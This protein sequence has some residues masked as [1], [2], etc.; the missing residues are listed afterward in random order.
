MKATITPTVPNRRAARIDVKKACAV[1][2]IVTVTSSALRK[3]SGW[4]ASP[5][6]ARVERLPVASAIACAFTLLMRFSAVSA[7]ARKASATISRTMATSVQTSVVV[8]SMPNIREVLAEA[9]RR[10]TVPVQGLQQVDL[11]G[12]HAGTLLGLGVVVAEHVQDAVDDEQRQLVVDRAGVG[13]RL[14]RRHARA[15]DHVTEQQRQVAGIGRGAIGTAPVR[16]GAVVDLDQLAV[17]RE[18]QHVG[19]A[20]RRRGTPRSGWRCRPRSRTAG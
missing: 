20:R 17:D 9:D 8:S 15:H 6:R 16:T 7:M 19:G 1:W 18:G 10:G 12:P 4:L 11:A 14:R 3:R 2:Q 13:G 5:A